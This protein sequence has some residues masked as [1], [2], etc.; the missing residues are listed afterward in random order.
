MPDITNVAPSNYAVA[1][2]GLLMVIAFFLRRLTSTAGWFHSPSG[3]LVIILVSTILTS[4]AEAVQK[5]GLSQSVFVSAIG[6]GLL[7]FVAMSN[8]QPASKPG[9]RQPEDKS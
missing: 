7:T 2:G 3:G 9:L 8:T 5:H 6:S 1:I 4:C